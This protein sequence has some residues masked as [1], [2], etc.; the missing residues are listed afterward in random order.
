[1]MSQHL[2]SVGLEDLDTSLVNDKVLSKAKQ[3]IKQN[4]KNSSAIELKKYV[5]Y[6]LLQPF[7]S[8][9]LKGKADNKK[10]QLTIELANQ[11]FDL[12]IPIYRFT[13]STS[14]N[15]E[16]EV[17][18]LWIGYFKENYKIV[19]SWAELNWIQFLQRRNPNTPAITSK[20]S[21]PLNRETLTKQRK[22]WNDYILHNGLNCI[23]TDT[24]ITPDNFQLD[25]F[26]PWS[27]VGHDQHWNLIPII[28][29]TNL[30][31]SN[32]LPSKQYLNKFVEIQK[33]AIQYAITNNKKSV[34]EDH[35][36][37]L[38]CTEVELKKYSHQLET[39]FLKTIESLIDMAEIQGFDSDW[40][41]H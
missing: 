26:I 39:R 9:G 15:V 18:P 27:Y 21:P 7:F 1:M 29:S 30:A 10:N 35:L 3:L 14:K 8:Q 36:I 13:E 32:N 23:F 31:K 28:P 38:K 34:I 33:N 22:F 6:R 40:K 5:P 4:F 2:Q 37:G 20:I 17:H 19:E 12:N 11:N 41:P 16:L 25:H 24:P